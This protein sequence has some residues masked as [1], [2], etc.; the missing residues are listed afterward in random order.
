[1]DKPVCS[2]Q[3]HLQIS[4]GCFRSS[5]NLA[6][7]DDFIFVE[8]RVDDPVLTRF[9]SIEHFRKLF[10]AW[11]PWVLAKRADGLY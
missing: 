10:A 2:I 7:D 5:S 1:M 4:V 11:R 8:N 3:Q 9:H 6:Y